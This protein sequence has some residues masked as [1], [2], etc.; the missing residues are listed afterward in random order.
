MFGL[1]GRLHTVEERISKMEA[2]SK[3]IID[4]SPE[5]KEI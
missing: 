4:S 5:T 3:E 1:S 2:R